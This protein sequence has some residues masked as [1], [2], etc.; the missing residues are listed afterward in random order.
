MRT[1]EGLEG[2]VGVL[3]VWVVLVFEVV[4]ALQ[5]WRVVWVLRAVWVLPPPS[6]DPQGGCPYGVCV[7]VRVRVRVCVRVRVPNTHTREDVVGSPSPRAIPMPRWRG[8]TF[9]IPNSLP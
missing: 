2:V 8:T 3:L 9:F 6:W 7:R 5:V 1:Q 4:W